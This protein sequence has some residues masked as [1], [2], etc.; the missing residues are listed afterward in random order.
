MRSFCDELLRQADYKQLFIDLVIHNF[1]EE[2]FQKPTLDANHKFAMIVHDDWNHIVGNIVDYSR[3]ED[4]RQIQAQLK[5][6]DLGQDNL[7]MPFYSSYY[8]AAVNTRLLDQIGCHAIPDFCD[9]N[10]WGKYT[11]DCR[12]HG[13][14]P[15]SMQWRK[16]ALWNFIQIFP[17]I[18]PLMVRAR[19]SRE[20][21]FLPP[22]FNT[23]IGKQALAAMKSFELGPVADSE[24]FLSGKSALTFSIGSWITRQMDGVKFNLP[25]REF[26]AVAFR[27]DGQKFCTRRLQNIRTFSYSDA[28]EDELLRVWELIKLMLSRPLQLLLAGDSGF[29]SVRKD[30]APEE[31][32]WVTNRNYLEFFP[33]PET[34]PVS[35]QALSPELIA[36]LSSLFEYYYFYHGNL[37]DI[38]ALMDEKLLSV[39]TMT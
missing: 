31:H 8:L 18:M 11:A 30:I 39:E 34:P 12:K 1:Y 29:V 28:T 10:W 25:A 16:Y 19:G 2:S 3:F 4:Y 23:E 24:L 5:D 36:A 27:P 35:F 37:N 17:W 7:H 22:F 33:D 20:N 15:F 6:Y 14:P 9:L 21:L 26:Q 13:L 32:P 38:A